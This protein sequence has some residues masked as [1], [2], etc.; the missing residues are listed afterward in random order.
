MPAFI[1]ST[2]STERTNV[3]GYPSCRN[4]ET[5]EADHHHAG[6]GMHRLRDPHHA[7]GSTL[8]HQAIL[9]PHGQPRGRGQAPLLQPAGL[10]LVR[11]HPCREFLSLLLQH[12]AIPQA[13][14]RNSVLL[15]PAPQTRSPIQ[16][17]HDFWDVQSVPPQYHGRDDNPAQHCPV[18]QPV[19]FLVVFIQPSSRW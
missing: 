13:M 18:G 2:I 7:S 8:R 17:L 15:L 10:L 16:R 12:S 6:R 19:F 1:I 11:F 4:H 14:S 9:G 3:Q 5:T